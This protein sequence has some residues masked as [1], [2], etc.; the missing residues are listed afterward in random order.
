MSKG[1]CH[2]WNAVEASERK[3]KREEPIDPFLSEVLDD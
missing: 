2:M 3:V 1:R